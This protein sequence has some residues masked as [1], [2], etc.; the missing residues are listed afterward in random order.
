[1]IR[2]LVILAFVALGCWLYAMFDAISAP[3]NRIRV[4][5]KPVWVIVILVLNVV[6][7]ALW[8]G[9][10]RPRRSDLPPARAAATRPGWTGQLGRPAPPRRRPTAPDDDP[11][12]LR[13]LGNRP[14][15]D[16]DDG[17]D[18]RT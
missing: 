6:G 14:R 7:A 12:F 17:T 8:L 10:G 16:P 5:P 18:D 1:M 2:F 13:G 3:R 15:R 4:F 11:D 9:F